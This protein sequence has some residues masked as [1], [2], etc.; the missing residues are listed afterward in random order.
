MDT[1]IKV[2]YGYT[3]KYGQ[4][5]KD[6]IWILIQR[7]NMDASTKQNRDTHTKIKYGYKYKD[8][9]WIQV[10]RQNKDT[11]TQVEYVYKCKGKI[12]FIVYS[13]YFQT[14]NTK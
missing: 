14:Q 2:K 13:I 10:Q 8:R 5:Y 6:R 3:Y 9:I 11:S 1:S 7:Y 4:T 12:Q